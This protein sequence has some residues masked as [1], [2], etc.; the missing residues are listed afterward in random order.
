MTQ[1]R[2]LVPAVHQ[3]GSRERRIDRLHLLQELEHSD[4]REGNSKV[5]PAGEVELRD[6]SGS[7]VVAVAGLLNDQ[8]RKPVS[9][10][11]G[12]LQ[13]VSLG[14]LEASS[15]RLSSGFFVQGKNYAP[16]CAPWYCR[17]SFFRSGILPAHWAAVV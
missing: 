1:R 16:W 9:R 6:Q 11:S 12:E 4:G 7:F 17:R 5:G 10:A 2:L 13:S 14:V 3:D 15:S 8:T